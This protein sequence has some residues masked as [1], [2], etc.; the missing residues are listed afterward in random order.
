[1]FGPGLLGKWGKIM[2][3]NDRIAS[4][5]PAGAS[6]T[7]RPIRQLWQVPTFLLGVA[8]FLGAWLKC[9]S[10]GHCRG[11]AG[12]ELDTASKLLQR[13]DGNGEPALD[14]LR[15]A[16]ETP[17]L[18]GDR[19]GEAYFLLGTAELRQ[20]GRAQP[21][22]ALIL[23]Q[24]A[25]QDL[26]EAERLGVPERLQ[27]PFRFRLA[28]AGFHTNDDP[29]RVVKLMSANIDKTEDWE[30]ADAYNLLTQAY[31]RL[32]KPDYKAALA[33]NEKLRKDIAL[34]P[35]EVLAPARLLG[36]ELLLQLKRPGEARTVLERVGLLATP[37]IQARAR[38]LRAQSFQ[39]ESKWQEAVNL[40]KEAL[41][42]VPDG[43]AE[44]GWIAYQM[45]VCYRNLKSEEA[46]NSLEE[47][48]KFSN[49]AEAQAAALS[50]AELYLQKSRF[51]VAL[52]RLTLAV[53]N[54][55]PTGE[56]KNSLVDL[57]QV[58]GIFER[59]CQRYRE[60][61]RFELAEQTLTAYERLAEKNRIPLIR[62][63][64]L[65]DWA[66]ARRKAAPQ[67]ENQQK[68]DDEAR[69]LF[70]K[71]GDA[72]EKAAASKPAEQANLLWLAI[73]CYREAPDNGQVIALC[74]RFLQINELVERKG[75]GWYVLGE[76][77]RQEKQVAEAEKAYKQCLAQS[78]TPFAYRARYQ[79]ALSALQLATDNNIPDEAM[80]TLNQNLTLIHDDPNADA[81]AKEKTLYTLGD[82]YFKKSNYR[83]VVRRLEE[84]LL[85]FPNSPDAPRARYQLA[86]S[87]RQ[88]AIEANA[89]IMA[90]KY[91]DP[92][93]LKLLR[94][95]HRNWMT[96][97]AHEFYQLAV[98]LDKPEA[99]GFLTAEER[100]LIPFQAADCRFNLGKYDE[101]LKL[102]EVL[103][104]RFPTPPQGLNA[105]AGTVRCLA[106]LRQFDEMRKRLDEIREVIKGLEDPQQQKEWEEWLRKAYGIPM[107]GRP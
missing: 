89:A 29:G 32:P 1:M 85:P 90:G 92:A 65:T 57:T 13:A 27:G 31:L 35:E 77:L 76:A 56:W 75:E 47:C 83:E 69:K 21:G 30:K 100:T 5:E 74:K 14:I 107:P 53:S 34:V 68:E 50:L 102:Y 63:E 39:D 97:A 94:D 45:G 54:V 86:E 23:Y 106:A 82:L 37:T 80:D 20:A 17:D 11:Q 66:R 78:L 72:Y 88:L 73:G 49:G 98:F 67:A 8:L 95:E 25:R 15:K 58:R 101:A 3:S 51:D 19:L 28:K 91:K 79:L 96:R 61:Y 43:S 81:W 26:L 9:H 103:V 41:V 12:E 84:A 42:D 93:A 2:N 24:R 52:Q 4:S 87:Y 105:L 40:W 38:R 6:A 7:D 60:A 44:R 46:I 59:A 18:L 10:Q 104:A 22:Q 33:A 62:A 99:A 64:V 16:L 36:G 70:C 48:C 71:A 55:P